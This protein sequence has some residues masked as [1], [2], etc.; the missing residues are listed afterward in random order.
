MWIVSIF[1]LLWIMLLWTWA[2]RYLFDP[3]LSVLWG[4]ILEV[5]LLDYGNSV[6]HFLRKQRIDHRGSSTVCISTSSVHKGSRFS[7]SSPTLVIYCFCCCF[8]TNHPNECEEVF[9]YDFDVHFSNDWWCWT[10]FHILTGHLYIFFA[11]WFFDG[12]A[13]S[14]IVR[15]LVEIHISSVSSFLLVNILLTVKKRKKN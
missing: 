13:C 1:W 11:F 8:N 4:Y 6:L 5:E 3:L 10:S 9:H 7:T 12:I 15:S 14:M 2:H